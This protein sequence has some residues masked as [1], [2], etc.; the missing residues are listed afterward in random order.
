MLR[1]LTP[2]LLFIV[3]VAFLGIGLT[4][5][6]RK[7]A[8]PLIDKPLPVFSLPQ[9]KDAEQT[10]SST[11]FL[12][13]VS[14]INVW[15]SWCVSCRV[16][17]PV[18]LDLANTGVVNIYGLNYKDKRDDALGWLK[19]YGDPYTLSAHDLAGMVGIDFGVYGAPETF[20]I[21]RKGIIRYK[22]IGPVTEDDLNE[23]ILPLIEKLK[24]ADL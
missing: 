24:V 8:S 4:L 6:P 21:D 11:D 3:L 5:D 23:V 16:E 17:H 22:H 10:L 9:L 1:K 18:L 13:E 12:N 14:L 2:L 15:A 19:Y 7:I 20:V